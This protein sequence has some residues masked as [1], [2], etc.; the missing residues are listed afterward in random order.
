MEYKN[1]IEILK[2]SNILLKVQMDKLQAE[3]EQRHIP[4]ELAAP[5]STL[6]QCQEEYE[7]VEL[8][9]LSLTKEL[10]SDE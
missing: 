9:I 2:R 8:A 4:E 3:L 7:A 5:Y 1:A 10:K 6:E